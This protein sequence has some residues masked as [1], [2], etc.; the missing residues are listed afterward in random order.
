MKV[1]KVKTGENK[2]GAL[3]KYLAIQ[4]I[5]KHFWKWQVKDSLISKC[6]LV[7]TM[8]EAIQKLKLVK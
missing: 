7:S 4:E 2:S 6:A 1:V 8:S 5:Q 3:T